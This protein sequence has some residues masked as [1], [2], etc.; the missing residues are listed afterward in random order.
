VKFITLDKLIRFALDKVICFALD[1][2]IRQD[3]VQAVRWQSKFLSLFYLKSSK[4]R[5]K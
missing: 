2:V 5:K 3:F 4:I 1:K